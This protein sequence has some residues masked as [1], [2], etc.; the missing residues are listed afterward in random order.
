MTTLPLARKAEGANEPCQ[1]CLNLSREEFVRRG[2]EYRTFKFDMASVTRGDQTHQCLPSS[3]KASK[4][5]R[6]L[7]QDPEEAEVLKGWLSRPRALQYEKLP[8]RVLDVGVGP[9]MDDTVR[10][11]QSSA[12]GE[13]L[14]A[15]LSHCWLRGDIEATKTTS[16]N[17]RSRLDGFSVFDLPDTFQ[18]AIAFCRKIGLQYIW[19]DSLCIVQDDPADWKREASAMDQV[20]AN[21][22]FTIAMHHSSNGS[23]PYKSLSL[24]I[25][26]Q[27]V[28]VH[29][30]RIPEMEDLVH[31]QARSP[32]IG[33]THQLADSNHWDSV[34]QRG[35]CFQ[36]R[37]LSSRMI[38]F[39]EHEFL[40]EARG[41]LTKCQCRRHWHFGVGLAGSVTAFVK[42]RP[43]DMDGV[44]RVWNDLAQQYTSR[45]FG[46]R[47][48]LLPGFAGVAK[49]VGKTCAQGNYIA[50]LWEKDLIKWLCWRSRE[51]QS[52]RAS[53]W[54]CE[55]CRPHP[56]RIWWTAHDPIPSWSWASR[57]G[58][59]EFVFESW[60]M[61]S[62]TE[63]AF[64]ERVECRMDSGNPYLRVA[65]LQP[66]DWPEDPCARYL[67]IRGS[68]YPCRNFTNSTPEHG[69]VSEG[70]MCKKEYGVVV[71]DHYAR[72]WDLTRP[73][74]ELL[75]DARK[76]GVE[77]CVDAGDD[78][79]PNASQIYL[80]P[81]Y[82]C[83]D[84]MSK[85]CLILRACTEK[86]TAE[87][88]DTDEEGEG[89]WWLERI[90]ISVLDGQRFGV[91]QHQELQNQVIHLM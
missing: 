49:L 77:Y 71:P 1:Y 64:I 28:A 39:T 35:W 26:E 46:H 50:G 87:A 33:P 74:L 7:W 25:G 62:W 12:K 32:A 83:P 5:I 75:V 15:A 82:E 58:P 56:R 63:V 2:F 9:D 86:L 11:H 66:E 70:G 27:V 3:I 48:D 43:H 81:L 14:Y 44:Y 67:R 41:A 85:T 24:V 20:Y 18:E 22:W 78:L 8:T 31:G 47:S 80:L 16:R 65:S 42:R 61:T 4:H 79:P 89:K 36:E 10:L 45:M 38:H 72:T 13:A 6:S 84:S 90:G 17:F 52:S 54:A 88:L 40:Y 59:C 69:F 23:M 19:I 30:R 76:V 68:L 60:K 37:A 57:L 21:A 73:I 53:A 34:V 55:N 91:M 29:V 51:W